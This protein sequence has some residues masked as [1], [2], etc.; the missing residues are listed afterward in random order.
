MVK[1]DTQANM[2]VEAGE[3]VSRKN[4]CDKRTASLCYFQD[5]CPSKC[6]FREKTQCSRQVGEGDLPAGSLWRTILRQ[7]GRSRTFVERTSWWKQGVKKLPIKTHRHNNVVHW[8]TPKPEKEEKK[9]IFGQNP[10]CNG[11]R[12]KSFLRGQFDQAW[13]AGRQ[14]ST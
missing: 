1:G 14:T 3:I 5:W 6:L 8:S 9:E 13:E 10:T 11:R 7:M 12:L 2:N 4:L